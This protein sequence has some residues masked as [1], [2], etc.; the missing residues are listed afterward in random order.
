MAPLTIF[1]TTWNT[2]LQ[3]S[4]AQ[5]QDLTSWLLPV[6]HRTANDPELPKGAVPDIYAIAVQELLPVHLAL[7]GLSGTV[8]LALTDRIV[9]LLS[10]H[11]KSLSG[12]QE[13]YR[14]VSRVAHGG[15]A[16]WVFARES[17]TRGRI[18]KPLTS[19]L[20]LYWFGLSNKGAV[21][22]RVPVQRSDKGQWENLTFVCAHL[23]AFDHN[24][25]RR[26]SQYRH[27]LTSL[28]F[29]GSDPLVKPAQVFETS[30]LFVMGDLN[31]RLTHL[32]GGAYPDEEGEG[33]QAEKERAKLVE[34]DT[35]KREQKMGRAFGGLREG[36]LTKF[37]PTYKRIVGK[38]NGFSRKRI[39]GYTDRILFAS[40]DDTPSSSSTVIK[41][42]G[43]TPQT[44]LS[45]H[46]PVHAVLELPEP[47]HSAASP[48]LAPILSQ[49]PPPHP[50][51]PLATP[52][53]QRIVQKIIGQ[54]LDK[55]I[56]WPWCILVLLGFGNTRAGMGVGAFAAMI[57][58]V[59]WSG[60]WVR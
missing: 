22:V 17:T 31:Y 21:G 55:L 30:H 28:V 59:W 58:G 54:I 39:P 1:L 32:P 4:K 7:A 43:S 47:S 3:G 49:P 19:T 6:L 8:L 24:V 51:W 41:H 48:H 34:V 36:D 35:L 57:W 40:H 38:V 9:S 5:E 29:Q 33:V 2:G 53:E 10:A 20:G 45:D 18:G 23:E 16:L 56:G 52:H 37:I 12:S 42:F 60:S 26:N 13:T 50:H 15:N 27:I 25:P 44:T 11:A 14:L 46:K